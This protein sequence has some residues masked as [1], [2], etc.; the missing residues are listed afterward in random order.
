MA[1][2]PAAASGTPDGNR[3]GAHSLAYLVGTAL[4]GLGVLLVLPF[5]TRL[6]GPAEFGRVA[7]G[8][9]AVQLVGTVAAAGLPQ[10]LLREH[11]RAS[12]GPRAARALAGTMVLGALALGV[13]GMAAV[14]ALG[15]AGRVVVGE[16]LPV[17]VAAAAL[18]VV[19]SGQS[20]SRARLR[21]SGFVLLAVASTVGA[22]LCGLLAARAVPTGERY[23]LAYTAGLLVSAGLALL[24]GRPLAPWA[25]P[26]RVRAGLRL[27]AP[28][29]PQAAAMLALLMGDVLLVRVLLGDVAAGEYQVALQLGNMPFVLA[30]ACFNAWAPLVLSHPHER[31]WAWTADTGTALLTVVV[32]GAAGVAALAPWLVDLV[33]STAFDRGAVSATLAVITVVAAA[34]MLYQGGSLAVLDAERTGA[35]L[36]A[37]LGAVVVLVVAAVVGV[38]LVGPAAG[39]AGG[40]GG[41]SGA[42]DAGAAL[43]AVAVAKVLAYATL[44]ALT[45]RSARSVSALRWP[46]AVPALLAASA[47]VGAATAAASLL[48]DPGTTASGASSGA[49]T[50]VGGARLVAAALV[51]VVTALVA[52]RVVRTLRG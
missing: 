19:V 52:P 17:V 46:R 40:A 21:P 51:L 14:A 13:V 12:D 23:L 16:W 48:T 36:V 30:V 15:A 35:L 32:L 11:H 33:T 34:Y 6:L 18:T 29:L 45:T 49:V 24:V 5:A 43:V 27:A 44:A 50:L 4:Q 8:L 37:A 1:S 41:A 2:T 26:D 9:V 42:D 31:R 25:Q 39:G 3:L 38:R 28:L 47:A 10:V 20:L 7:T 22:H